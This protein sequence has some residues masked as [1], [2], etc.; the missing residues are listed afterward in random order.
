MFLVRTEKALFLVPS[1]QFYQH[2]DGQTG[3]GCPL[4]H[5]EAARSVLD[6]AGRRRARWM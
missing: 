4:G 3:Q 2:G 5:R 6:A 1:L